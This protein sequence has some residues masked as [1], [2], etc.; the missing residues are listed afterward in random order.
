[1]YNSSRRHSSRP[2][3]E[4]E[5][6]LDIPAHHYNPHSTP[7]HHLSISSMYHYPSYDAVPA[8]PRDI[9]HPLAVSHPNYV[10][11]RSFVRVRTVEIMH[12][13]NICLAV[14]LKSFGVI[15]LIATPLLLYSDTLVG[16]SLGH[17]ALIP[18]D[19]NSYPRFNRLFLRCQRRAKLPQ[20]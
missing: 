10:H 12:I 6:H 3:T 15:C 5:C 17:H 18:N 8:I 7:S 13:W 2:F 9:R 16:I 19:H 20:Y 14:D 11:V 1:M 4:N